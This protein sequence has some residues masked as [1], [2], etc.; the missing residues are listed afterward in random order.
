[1]LNRILGETLFLNHG[2]TLQ[3]AK[4]QIRGVP[5]YVE[6]NLTLHSEKEINRRKLLSMIE[7]DEYEVTSYEDLD[8]DQRKEIDALNLS[9]MLTEALGEGEKVDYRE[10][11]FILDRLAALER[12][13]LIPTVLDNLERLFPVAEAVAAFFTQL[14]SLTA[15]RRREIGTA[16]LKPIL[17]A[18]E[19][20][21][22]DY[23]SMWVLSVFQSD[24][25]WNHAEDL[26]AI[27]R[28]TNSDA[29]RRFAALALARSGSRAQA[30]AMKEYLTAASPLCRTAML[31]ATARLGK[32]ERRHLRTSL[33]LT[34]EMERLSSE[35]S[36]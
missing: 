19:Q 22:P 6:K 29:V 27:F 7:T 24:P 26:L 13:E 11:S 16:L 34:D 10:V 18:H 8:E 25:D 14:G 3:T 5:E 30:L 17:N 23:Y 32:D 31:L 1:M 28:G 21:T 33:K 35:S 20:K 36:L 12:L 4:T 9:E 2:L 15:D